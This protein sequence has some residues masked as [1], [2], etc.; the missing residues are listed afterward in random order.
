MII[1]FN[2][3]PNYKNQQSLWYGNKNRYSTMTSVAFIT[4]N[5]LVCCSYYM[6][7]M[8]LV[9]FNLETK[10]YK[11]LD[12]I[13]TIGDETGKIPG[14]T[15]LIDYKVLKNNTKQ[16]ITSNF[17]QCSMSIYELTKN[18]TKL[19]YIRSI[20]NKPF[21]PH[22]GI[23]YHPTRENIVFI[24]TS[25]TTNPNCGVYAI[26]INS[27]ITTPFFGIKQPGWLCKDICFMDPNNPINIFVLYC[28]SAPNPTIKR[29]YSAKIVMYYLDLDQR[30][31][32][33]ISEIVIEQHHADAV[34]YFDGK[35]YTTV[36][37]VDVPGRV[38]VH[39]VN[40][41]TGEITYDKS[42]TGYSFPHGIDIKYGMI[43]VSEYGKS[44]I[45]LGKLDM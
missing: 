22:H 1:P 3:N 14:P 6:R 39:N 28:D 9:Q 41:K 33:K 43:A 21:G 32:A 2:F 20:V 13:P 45:I 35:L 7:K 29:Q 15:D 11:I 5:L 26:D 10:Q 44:D 30:K 27:K 8:Y 24:G 40:K 31:Y 25:G 42:I 17:N 16:I 34:K 38:I 12:E 23:A 4:K 19:K 37:G 36:E 18:N